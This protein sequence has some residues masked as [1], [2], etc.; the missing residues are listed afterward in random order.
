MNTCIVFANFSQIEILARMEGNNCGI[1]FDCDDSIF[2]QL[3]SHDSYLKLR[4]LNLI[5]LSLKLDGFVMS[6][7]G[8][9]KVE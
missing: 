8:E 3:E 4:N 9:H 6:L 2:V 5:L 7:H 1:C